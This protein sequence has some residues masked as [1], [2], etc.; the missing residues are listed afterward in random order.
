MHVFK[1]FIIIVIVIEIIQVIIIQLNLQF[2]DFFC[3]NFRIML[4]TLREE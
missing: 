2:V 1:V 3:C 4:L